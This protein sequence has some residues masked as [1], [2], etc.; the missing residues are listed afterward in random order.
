MSVINSVNHAISV[1][2]KHDFQSVVTI[3]AS[4]YD[5][6]PVSVLLDSIEELTGFDCTSTELT[7]YTREVSAIVDGVKVYSVISIEECVA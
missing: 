1:I 4:R 5:F 3:Y 2:E 7:E 6:I